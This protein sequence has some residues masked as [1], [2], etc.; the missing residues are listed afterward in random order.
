MELLGELPG[1]SFGNFAEDVTPDGSIIVGSSALVSE[2]PI[3]LDPIVWDSQNGTRSLRT[4]LDAATGTPL[5]GWDQLNQAS[6]I[7][8]DA[9]VISGVGKNPSGQQEGWVMLFEPGE[10]IPEPPL[11]GDYNLNGTVDAADYTIWAD[12]GV[13]NFVEPCSG[14]DSNCNGVIDNQDYQT[15]KNHFGES[16][17]N[18]ASAVGSAASAS[19]ANVPEPSALV[20]VCSIIVG[21]AFV[22]R[23]PR[24]RRAAF[25]FSCR[26]GC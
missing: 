26:A 4:I 25:N 6:G 20:L 5:V 22:G 3:R 21:W 1:G 16:R 9:T 8:A 24:A 23:S 13:G 10:V 2:S 11:A 7:S 17:P 12:Q 14:A 19:V 18:G 15:W